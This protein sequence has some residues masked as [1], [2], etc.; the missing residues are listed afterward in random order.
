MNSD[1][2]VGLVLTLVVCVLL[3]VYALGPLVSTVIDD[4]IAKS[5]SDLYIPLYNA[6]KLL[7]SLPA[8]ELI[9]ATGIIT[10]ASKYS[11]D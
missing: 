1:T 7:L 3:D 6:I 10:L 2:I 5:P 11:G 4:A 8:T 9:L